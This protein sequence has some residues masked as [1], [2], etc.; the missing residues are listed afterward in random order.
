MGLMSFLLTAILARLLSPENMATFFLA[1]SA[2]LFLAL[3]GRFGLDNT[4][5]RLV[6]ES[7]SIGDIGRTKAILLV[8]ISLVGGISTGLAVLMYFGPGAWLLSLLF[9]FQQLDIIVGFIAVWSVVLSFQFLLGEIFR[10]L[11]KINLAVASGGAASAIISLVLL[12]ILWLSR[13]E[14]ELST[15]LSIIILAGSL[16]MIGGL[17][18]LYVQLKQFGVY[19]TST[20]I[21]ISELFYSSVPLWLNAMTHYAL[22]FAGLWILGAFTT[23]NDVAYYGAANRMLVFA[24]IP[25]VIVNSVLPPLISNLNIQ[26]KHEQLERILRGT[27]TIA[28]IPSATII[29]VLLV[30]PE[31]IMSFAFGT[32]YGPASHILQI[33]LLSQLAGSLSGSCGYLLMMTGHQ[34]TLMNITVVAAISSVTIG[35]GLVKPFGV[36]GIAWVTTITLIIQQITTVVCAHKMTGVWS[37]FSLKHANQFIKKDIL[38]AFI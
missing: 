2:A 20:N 10:S 16:N 30:F 38:K 31:H 3:S 1:N 23:G 8:G 27:A 37:C 5:L 35:L 29:L 15:V 12:I 21:K 13:G 25:L 28:C 9:P 33:L 7:I 32:S 24:G 19:E 36:T 17:S 6:S 22:S 4:L 11:K 34:K 26:G 18:L 14:S